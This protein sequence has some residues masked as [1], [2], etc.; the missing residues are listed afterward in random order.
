[1]SEAEAARQGAE[2]ARQEAEA[3]QREIASHLERGRMLYRQGQYQGASDECDSVLKLDPSNAAAL[4][5]KKQIEQTRK[6]LS[7]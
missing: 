7:Q 6:I 2:A 4:A 1:M 5:L 3:R